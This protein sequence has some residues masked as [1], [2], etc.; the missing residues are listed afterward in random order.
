MESGSA[1]GREGEMN[2]PVL[3][4]LLVLMAVV[5]MAA[6]R[7]SPPPPIVDVTPIGDALRFLAVAVVLGGIISGIFD[8]WGKE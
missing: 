8:L 4:R 7:K 6:C 1:G 2:S 3:L 5:S